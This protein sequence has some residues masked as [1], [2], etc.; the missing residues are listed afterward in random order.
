MLQDPELTLLQLRFV[1]AYLRYLYGSEAA[2]VAGY[3]VRCAHQQA[4]ENMRK[5]KIR[6]IIDK[7]M[8]LR[9]TILA[10]DEAHILRIWQRQY[11]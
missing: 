6:R 8:Q 3:S 10:V 5:P 7:G 9:Y 11:E 4:Y 1:L 2:R